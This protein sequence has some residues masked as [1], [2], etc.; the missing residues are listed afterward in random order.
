[1]S[2]HILAHWQHKTE[3]DESFL[4]LPDGC[5]DVVLVQSAQ[6]GVQWFFSA[7]QDAPLSVT[8]SA[9][10]EVEGFR[11]AAGSRLDAQCLNAELARAQSR[12]D[13]HAAIATASRRDAAIADALASLAAG[14]A[15]PT[16]PAAQRRWQRLF[17]DHAGRPPV[18]WR[19]LARARQAGRQLQCGLPSVE[20]A[21]L[22]GYSD[23][24]HLS[25]EIRRWFG[26]SPTQAASSIALAE[27]LAANAYA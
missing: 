10:A 13:I 16:D 25:R 24:A 5:R 15:I 2:E 17:R 14:E 6:G 3:S 9:G 12:A 4:I 11:L 19:N 21:A 27:T 26:L 1:M 8:L 7:L 23:Q 20:V 18:F 22:C